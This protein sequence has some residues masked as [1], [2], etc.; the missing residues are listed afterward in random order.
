MSSWCVRSA[1]HENEWLQRS[2]VVRT[3]WRIP[4]GSGRPL[5]KTPPSWFTSPHESSINGLYQFHQ[6]EYL[7]VC[8]FVAASK[9][10]IDIN[11]CSIWPLPASDMDD[12]VSDDA[13]DTDDDCIFVKSLC[14]N[15]DF[16][17]VS[18]QRVSLVSKSIG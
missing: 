7:P 9:S 2:T 15:S 5:T 6:T 4:F 14:S 8:A 13:G 17:F 1:Y 3:F 11:F 16:C 12:E 10:Y 18:R